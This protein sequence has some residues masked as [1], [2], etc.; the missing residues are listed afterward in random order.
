M[1]NDTS[2]Q[3]TQITP[4]NLKRKFQKLGGTKNALEKLKAYPYFAFVIHGFSQV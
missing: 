4:A 3:K 2:N 1:L